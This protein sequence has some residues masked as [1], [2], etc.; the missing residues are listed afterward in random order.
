VPDKKTIPIFFEGIV[1]KLLMAMG[2]RKTP[3][4]TILT[5]ATWKADKPNS[6][7]F[8]NIK[9]LPQM[10]ESKIN[11]IQL[12]NRSLINKV[13]GSKIEGFKRFLYFYFL[14]KILNPSLWA[15]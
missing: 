4:A 2:S 5:E 6:P 11:N 10:M 3:A 12:D 15:F 7:F 1:L 14:N 13:L 9:L 8:I